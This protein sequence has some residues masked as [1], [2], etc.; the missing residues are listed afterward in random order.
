MR[1]FK[2]KGWLAKGEKVKTSFLETSR[3][4]GH[5]PPALP[6]L[7]S[8]VPD[9]HVP[10]INWLIK[11]VLWRWTMFGLYPASCMTYISDHVSQ[12]K[13]SVTLTYLW[14]GRE[15]EKHQNMWFR[16]IA[17]EKKHVFPPKAHKYLCIICSGSHA[18]NNICLPY[19]AR[20]RMWEE[21]EGHSCVRLIAPPL[22]GLMP[23]PS[24]RCAT[25]GE[26]KPIYV[27]QLRQRCLFFPT[28]PPPWVNK[29]EI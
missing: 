28:S 11:A 22:P 7:A 25:A 13:T 17:N 12:F 23:A 27:P 6:Q 14:N 15:G 24:H 1:L 29:M 2:V 19:G 10:H 9:V 26:I 20:L 5:W 18:N 8:D 16:S 4:F 21:S 3:L